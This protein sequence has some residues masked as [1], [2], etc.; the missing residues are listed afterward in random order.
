MKRY[1]TVLAAMSNAKRLEILSTLVEDELPV[2]K[3]ASQ[4]GLSQ[5]ALSQHLAKLR[6]AKLVQTRRDA[7]TIY[8][9]SNSDEVKAVLSALR[10]TMGEQ[11]RY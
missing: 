6:S 4:V 5:S 8:Y 10:Q 11:A 1:A 3:L 7:Q 2:G 9:S